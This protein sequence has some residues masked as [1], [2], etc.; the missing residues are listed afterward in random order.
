[1]SSIAELG[2]AG[3]VLVLVGLAAVDLVAME[4]CVQ[5]NDNLA[6]DTARQIASR[7]K[8][9][10]EAGVIA[11]SVLKSFQTG[12]LITAVALANTPTVENSNTTTVCTVMKV[13]LP[14]PVI[15]V[16][17]SIQLTSKSTERLTT[18]FL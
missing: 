3:L 9:N 1:M 17:D 15:G 10:S 11:G 2:A 16:P 6:K 7:A 8:S 4:I 5:I 14:A 18:Q 12:N 13:H